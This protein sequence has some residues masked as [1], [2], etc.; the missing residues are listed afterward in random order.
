MRAVTLF[1]NEDGAS[2][3]KVL[4]ALFIYETLRKH[5]GV[6]EILHD[7]NTAQYRICDSLQR[8]R[9][10]REPGCRIHDL[11]RRWARG[12]RRSVFVWG[13]I[14]GSGFL[15]IVLGILVTSIG[16]WQMLVV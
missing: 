5:P 14:G 1:L 7:R 6:I 10:G 12:D 11:G 8:P 4:L 15:V 2:E 9:V 13:A 16:L 3:T